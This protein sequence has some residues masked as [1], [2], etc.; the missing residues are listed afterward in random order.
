MSIDDL[1]PLSVFID[2]ERNN[3]ASY[4]S[5]LPKE[6]VAQIQQI[7]DKNHFDYTSIQTFDKLYEYINNYGTK[8]FK[9]YY[10]MYWD[11]NKIFGLN[12]IVHMR[13][14]KRS[15]GMLRRPRKI[16]KLKRFVK[17]REII[18]RRVK[19][20]KCLE[21]RVAL[22][23]RNFKAFM[24][25]SHGEY[26]YGFK[27]LYKIDYNIGDSMD[28]LKPLSFFIEKERNNSASYL[29]WL[30]REIVAIIQQ[31]Y[32]DYFDYTQIKTFDELYKYIENS[33]TKY[34]KYYSTMF[35]NSRKT[36]QNNPSIAYIRK[37]R[38]RHGIIFTKSIRLIL[39]KLNFREKMLTSLDCMNGLS[40]LF[41]IDYNNIEGG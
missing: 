7:Y 24:L 33:G 40:P 8:Y 34:F 38:Q 22:N 17:K 13:K 36:Y 25:S 11:S 28:D 1:K 37:T 41:K 31:M 35:W 5:W 16:F 30:P 19:G 32:D 18:F 20:F 9:R 23:K 6:I 10:T 12:E 29:S 15:N 4:L 3:K 14:Q 27:P 26:T 39:N 21:C 2:K